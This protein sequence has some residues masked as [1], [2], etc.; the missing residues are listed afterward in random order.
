MNNVMVND[1]QVLESKKIDNDFEFVLVFWH[2]RNEF[3]VWT[4]NI[5]DNYF[6]LG[7]YFNNIYSAISY[8]ETL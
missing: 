1:K 2:S 6:V 4:R 3:V 5:K 7:H 8:F